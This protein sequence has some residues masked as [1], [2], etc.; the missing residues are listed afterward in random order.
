MKK[1]NVFRKIYFFVLKLYK[2]NDKFVE[3]KKN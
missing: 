1:H 2:P 3:L